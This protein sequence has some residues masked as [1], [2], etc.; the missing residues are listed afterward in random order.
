MIDEEEI[1]IFAVDTS[2]DKKYLIQVQENI[3]AKNLKN[4]LQSILNTNNFEIRFKNNLYEGDKILQFEDGDTIYI[5][6]KKEENK[7]ED[8]EIKIEKKGINIS[9][10]IDKLSGIL[11]FFLIKYISDKI[12]DLD[13]IYNN[14]YLKN[15]IYE[16][17]SNFEL[18]IGID[19]II[20][21]NIKTGHELNIIS[22][23]N[24]ILSEIKNE[25]INYLINNLKDGTKNGIIFFFNILIQY[26]QYN[27]F[28]EEDLLNAL[29]NSY[30]EYSISGIELLSLNNENI[31]LNKLKKCPNKIIKYLYKTNP[32]VQSN[33]SKN[34]T[35]NYYL[36][37]LDYIAYKSDKNE[38]DS[39]F[40]CYV[41]QTYY[42]N[43]KRHY[44]SDIKNYTIENNGIVFYNIKPDTEQIIKEKDIKKEKD[45]GKF[46]ANRYI[47]TGNEQ[48]L[49]LFNL[50]FKRNESLIIW[51]DPTFNQNN[52]QSDIILKSIR[53]VQKYF[54]MN[55]YMEN[56]FEKALEIILRKKYNKIIL[57]SN[58]G[59]DL[60]GKRFIEVARKILNFPVIGLFFSRN[61]DHLKWIKDFPNV[62]ITQNIQFFEKY[63]KNY[64]NNGLLELKEQIE[65]KF[66]IQLNFTENF[67]SFPTLVDKKDLKKIIFKEIS[68]N[69]R[70]VIIKS[71][72]NS[73][74]LCL[75]KKGNIIFIKE[76]QISNYSYIWYITIIDNEITF[77]INQFYLGID[78]KNKIVIKE[79]YMKI[80]KLVIIK[81]NYLFYF[82]NKNFVLTDNNKALVQRENK[83]YQDQLF[84]LVNK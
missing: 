62:L 43:N 27:S 48:V 7:L 52:N 83:N 68:P 84:S 31:Y 29:K 9:I 10:N 63:I 47:I 14:I 57:I 19:N 17:K 23:S 18:N 72:N 42:D 64:N 51:R 81:K 46:I 35:E 53:L 40:S 61:L 54:K 5:Y 39:S 4:K 55:I 41:F 28:F 59:L 74:V 32:K 73:N 69:F 11:K 67:L 80:W 65:K 45:K 82:G 75:D 78:Q 70:K 30:F 8:N 16:L 79:E 38:I 24:Y 58:I 56:S 44:K 50:E 76:E 3:K 71:K 1:D 12:I 6:P 21:I 33:N 13:K 60:S 2:S 34:I 36:D 26:Q 22:Y 77:F 49:P 66:K 15:I 37:Q 25:D 20:K